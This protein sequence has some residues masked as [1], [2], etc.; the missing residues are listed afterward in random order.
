MR[1]VEG[2]WSGLGMMRERR[3]GWGMRGVEGHWSGLG[4]MRERR[5]GW[6]MRG[7]EGHWSGLGMMRERRRGW[8]IRGV[9]GARGEG[10]LTWRPGGREEGGSLAV[11]TGGGAVQQTL[12]KGFH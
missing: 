8:G 11:Q 5:R 6:G 7:V 3:R 9:E 4:V 12:K 10:L 2:H 1:G